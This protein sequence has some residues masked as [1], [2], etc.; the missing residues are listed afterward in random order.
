VNTDYGATARSIEERA[1]ARAD[2]LNTLLKRL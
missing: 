2:K 1:G